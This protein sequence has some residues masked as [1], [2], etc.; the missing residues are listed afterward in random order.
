[1]TQ[2]LG[3]F[4]L[5]AL[6]CGLLY[7]LF[8]PQ[9]VVLLVIVMFPLEQLLQVYFPVFAVY[10]SFINYSIGLIALFAVLSALSQGVNPLRGYKNPATIAVA[11]LFVMVLAG[12]AFSPGA[13]SAIGMLFPRGIAYCLLYLVLLPL[14]IQQVRDLRPI[15]TGLMIVGSIIVALIIL[16]PQAN[17]VNNRLMLELG[18]FTGQQRGNPLAIA[19]LGGMM[20]IVAV[21]I[22][23]ERGGWLMLAVRIVAFLLGIGLAFKSGSRGQVLAAIAVTAVCFPIARQL[24]NPVQY[25]LTGAGVVVLLVGFYIA[26]KLFID[27]QQASRWELEGMQRSLENRFEFVSILLEAYLARPHLW[28]TGLGTNAFFH[29]S[30][31]GFYPHNFIVQVLCEQG[32]VGLTLVGVAAWYT[33]KCGWRMWDAHRDNLSMRSTVAIVVAFCLYEFLLSLKQGSYILNG[34]PLIWWL[35]LSKVATREQSLAAATDVDAWESYD[36]QI[37]LGYAE[38][39][40]DEGD[41]WQSGELGAAPT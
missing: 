35:V 14:V 36:S 27:A 29:F 24:K 28:L 31:G 16:N 11:V 19:T 15:F 13:G 39:H 1:M 3:V 40:G 20:A 9:W 21:L 22:R 8:R 30:G 2:V 4:I 5:A 34:S 25:F 26:F 32:V 12:L 18:S 23:Y 33:F 6:A 41:D 38:A 10:G 7:V 17:L 37:A